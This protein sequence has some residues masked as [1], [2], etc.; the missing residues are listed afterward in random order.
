MKKPILIVFLFLCLMMSACSS[1]LMGGS[2][3][4]TTGLGADKRTAQQV[5]DDN[6]ITATIRS[7]YAQDSALG[8]ANLAVETYVATVTLKGTVTSFAI[9]DRAVSIARNTDKVRGVNNQILVNTNN[10]Q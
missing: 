3:S 7:R 6:A 8:A 4:G 1:M 9:R 5:T 2:A 10:K